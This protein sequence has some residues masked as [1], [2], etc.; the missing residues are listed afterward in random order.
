MTFPDQD[1][2]G[3]AKG[4]R[5]IINLALAGARGKVDY[6]SADATAEDI[7]AF[8]PHEWVVNAVALALFSGALKGETDPAYKT[9][10]GNLMLLGHIIAS[11]GN[12]S[13]VIGK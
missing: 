4:V 11:G 5:S 1:L 12:I 2:S 6:L 10:P 7:R 3:V 13:D 9:T 8:E